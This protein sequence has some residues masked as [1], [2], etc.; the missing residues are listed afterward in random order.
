MRRAARATS[1]MMMRMRRACVC[2]CVVGVKLYAARG[3]D[4]VQFAIQ[5]TKHV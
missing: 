3:V 4:M 1:T 2:V 5:L